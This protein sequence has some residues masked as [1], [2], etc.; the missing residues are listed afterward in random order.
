MMNYLDSHCH[1]NDEAYDE[2]LN[3]VLDRMLENRV[4]RAMIICVT[5]DDYK[6]TLGICREGIEFKKAIGV[7]PEYTDISEDDFNEYA[8]LM[9]ECDAIG[10]IGLDY[11]WY[12]DT[13]EKQKELF[14]RQIEIA[15]E[16]DKP[17]IVH[18]RDAMGDCFSILKEHRCRGVLH[19]YSGS[20]EMAR[21]LVKLGYY[22]SI[23]GPVTWK[24]AKEPLEVIRNV[25]LDRLL[26]ETDCP[27]LTPAP[28]RG[29][30]NEPSYVVH[31]ARR[32]MEELGIG[33]EEFLK[34][35]NAN[36]DHLFGSN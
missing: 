7:Y 29:K 31:T 23:A 13:R 9:K 5:L 36:Y 3:E 12:P 21:E 34:Q 14:I 28:N 30:R 15:K 17:V 8:R 24:N 1:L 27:Y 10:E 18:A 33:E 6:K 22:I 26:I 2:D 35:V 32:I 19:C 25:P 11:H 16:T 4:S 20:A